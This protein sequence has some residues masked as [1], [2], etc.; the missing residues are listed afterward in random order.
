MR[1][2]VKLINQHLNQQKSQDFVP[3]AKAQD[4]IPAVIKLA[5]CFGTRPSHA[6]Y[7]G[8]VL[9][10]ATPLLLC[11]YLLFLHSRHCISVTDVH[12]SP[13]WHHCRVL[14]ICFP[15]WTLRATDCMLSCTVVSHPFSRLSPHAYGW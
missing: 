10:L 6:G 9:R 2:E 5:I 12:Q 14:F 3:T 13:R 7:Q 11:I 1:A 4:T 15:A 8:L